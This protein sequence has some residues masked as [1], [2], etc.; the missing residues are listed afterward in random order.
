M[1]AYFYAMGE[2]FEFLFTAIFIFYIIRSVFRLITGLFIPDAGNRQQQAPPPRPN[3]NAY[4]NTSSSTGRI[5]V[6]YK[7]QQKKGAI[8]DNEGE[9]IDYEEVK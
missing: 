9:F 6:D 8:P 1:H 7:P 5:K 4:S 2:V 3:Y